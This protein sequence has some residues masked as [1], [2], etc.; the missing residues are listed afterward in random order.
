MMISGCSL[1]AYWV[2]NYIAD[3]IFQCLPAIVG[4]AGIHA[5]DIDVPQVEWIFLVVVFANPA[6]IYAFSFLLEK[7]ESG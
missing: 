2:G 7:D 6:F 4:I 3:I 1:S 5:F